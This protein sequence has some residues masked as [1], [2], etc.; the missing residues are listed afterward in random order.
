LIETT[1]TALSPLGNLLG[2][3][4]PI[5]G[6]VY[7][8]L[9]MGIGV[10]FLSFGL[11]YQVR[12]MLPASLEKGR[13]FIISLAPIVL[14]FLLVEWLVYAGQESFSGLISTMGAVLT[15]LLGGVFPILLLA[16]SRQQGE[17]VPQR[18]FAFLGKPLLLGLVYLIY[19]G[20]VFVYGLFIWD[21]PLQRIFALGMGFVVLVIPILV[22]RGG[23]FTAQ[24]VVELKIA[25]LDSFENATLSLTDRGKLQPC[26]AHLNYANLTET[27]HGTTLEI[28][29]YRELRSL[30]LEIPILE[31]KFMKVWVHRVTPEGNSEPLPASLKLFHG[32]QVEDLQVD[33]KTKKSFTRLAPQ[34][35][36][37]EISL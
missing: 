31:S 21:E 17:Y 7:V 16:A 20:G 37:L 19:A 26:L 35:H 3:P 36:R 14:I 23:A 28:P 5:L 24:A 10:V 33:P 11:F 2:G 18:A 9:A 12:E 6:V 22:I 13:Q 1:G 34:A 30:S 8:I 4:A 27:T 32:D 25:A 29:N 15:P